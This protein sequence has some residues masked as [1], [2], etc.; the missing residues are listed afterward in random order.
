MIF[1]HQSKN[2]KVLLIA[3]LAILVVGVFIV[4]Y[5]NVVFQEGNPWP[6]IKGIAQLTFGNK[7]VVKLDIG[8]NKYI[9][10]SNNPE[11]IKSFMKEKGYVF[12]EQ[13]GSGYLFKSDSGASAV[14]TH[15]YYSRFYSLWNITENNNNSD[16][17][18][19]VAITNDQGITFQYPKELLAKYVSVTEWPP[20]IK[21]ETGTFSCKTTPQEVS[22]MSDITSQR[23]VDNRTYCVNVKNEGAAGSVYSSYTY[24]T[25]K[26]G[27]LVKVGF[28]LQYPNCNNYDEDQRK[29]CASEREAFDMDS[30]VDR[31][32]QSIVAKQEQRTLAEE[33]KECLPKSDTASH[34]KC[35]ELLATIG[36]FND[37]VN[38]GFSI[39]KSN[40]SQCT[41][42]DGRI[43]IDETN[44]DWS[45]A[46][47]ALNN[48]EVESVFQTHSKLIT[49]KLKNGNKVTAYEPQIDDV[50]KVVENL[51]GK[52]GDI[53]LATE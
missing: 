46:L 38:A 41:T 12:T 16:N 43:F 51:N 53:R 47:M 1:E 49:L 35:N 29:A 44:S 32:V 22:S 13:M 52:C 33:L 6:Q 37:C 40:P 42:P 36:N 25:A 31:I 20:V 18:L 7:D 45:V 10:K 2:K 39:M 4:F 27:K 17:N 3:S 5:S 28:T 26:N 23:M 19:W 14:A 24:T 30:T 21:I 15:R 11:L 34:E 8:E 9:T 48:C 50:M